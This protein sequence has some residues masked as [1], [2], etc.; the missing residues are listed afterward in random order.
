MGDFNEILCLDEK[1]GGRPR[2]TSQMDNFREALHLNGLCE[3]GWKGSKFTWNSRHNDATF[4]AKR[5][6]RAVANKQWMLK[7]NYDVVDV[8]TTGRFDHHSPPYYRLAP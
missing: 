3:L 5:P 7:V 4:T 2:Q 6:D 1:W 8:L